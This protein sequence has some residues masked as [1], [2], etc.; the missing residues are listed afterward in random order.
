MKEKTVSKK[1]SFAGIN[2]E[3]EPAIIILKG[4]DVGVPP[5]ACLAYYVSECWS[6][7]CFFFLQFQKCQT[8]DS[9]SEIPYT[10]LLL[11]N[12]GVLFHGYMSAQ[13]VIVSVII[14]TCSVAPFRFHHLC[15]IKQPD[16]GS[17]VGCPG[18]A[19]VRFRISGDNCCLSTNISLL[20]A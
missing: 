5:S 3:T 2:M 4:T 18:A 10:D 7:Q 16:A 9:A 11:A 17:R 20:P 19:T 6:S 15:S 14:T 1:S 12:C 13:A 8:G